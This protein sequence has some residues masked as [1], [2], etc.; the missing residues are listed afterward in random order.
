[1]CWLTCYIPVIVLS[2]SWYRTW[3]PPPQSS[4]QP[5]IAPRAR[6]RSNSDLYRGRQGNTCWRL[7]ASEN[8]VTWSWW[9]IEDGTQTV[10]QY[11]FRTKDRSKICVQVFI[12][13]ELSLSIV[14]CAFQ[15]TFMFIA[16]DS[17]GADCIIDVYSSSTPY[18]VRGKTGR[19]H[20]GRT[21]MCLIKWLAIPV[22]DTRSNMRD[23][24]TSSHPLVLGWLSSP[25]AFI[26]S[27][28]PESTVSL[29]QYSHKTMNTS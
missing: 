17:N 22:I 23:D 5:G 25:N 29:N 12:Y 28:S 21:W 20:L 19:C 14:L 10:V 24:W 15:S 4:E 27:C 2:P 16:I 18:S 26:T 9:W 13:A 7:W 8:V 11:R 6:L 1:M 3:Q